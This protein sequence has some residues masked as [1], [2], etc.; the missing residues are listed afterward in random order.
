MTYLRSLFAVFIT[1]IP[2][3]QN[4][5]SYFKNRIHLGWYIIVSRTRTTKTIRV[6]YTSRNGGKLD[7]VDLN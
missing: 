5:I 1:V 4:R 7:V 3:K 2:M 6:F